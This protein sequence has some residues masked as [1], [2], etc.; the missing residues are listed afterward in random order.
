VKKDEIIIQFV[1][2]VKYVLTPF[3]LCCMVWKKKKWFISGL[4]GELFQRV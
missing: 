3:A 4:Q 1:L 2:G